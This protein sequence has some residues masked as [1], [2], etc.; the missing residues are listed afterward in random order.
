MTGRYINAPKPVEWTEA[1]EASG[2]SVVECSELLG[3]D[4]SSWRG[5]ER[6]RHV[7]A[8]YA[9]NHFKHLARQHNKRKRARAASMVVAPT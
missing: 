9:L 6:G 7:G 5:W 4:P 1:R 8:R 2:L 3:V